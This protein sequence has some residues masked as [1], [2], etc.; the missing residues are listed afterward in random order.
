MWT[1]LGALLIAFVLAVCITFF[2][3]RPRLAKRINAGGQLVARELHG[4]PPLASGAA[5]CEAISDPDRLALKGIGVIALS[6]NA[7][8]FGNSKSEHVLIV[9]RDRITS[10]RAATSVE[11]LGSTVRRPRPMLVV[12]WL[13]GRDNGQEV[14]FTVD[15]T[16]TW[17]GQLSQNLSPR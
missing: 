12:G 7:V 16:E 1:I 5:S 14:A 13:D 8:V 17:V 11:V 6:E 2:I 9:P 10:V 4:R 3:V 15:A